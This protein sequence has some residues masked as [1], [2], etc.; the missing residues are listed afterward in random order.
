MHFFEGAPNSLDRY[1]YKQL[2]IWHAYKY[3]VST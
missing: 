1:Y 3:K 2:L